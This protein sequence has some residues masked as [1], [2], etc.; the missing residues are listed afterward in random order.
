M[1]NTTRMPTSFQGFGIDIL[2]LG[3][4]L[5]G[6]L[7]IVSL[8]PLVPNDFWWHLKVGEWIYTH[9]SIPTTNMFAWSL[10]ADAP[11]FYGTWLGELLLY[12]LFRFGGLEL[13]IFTRTFLFGITLWLLASEARRR[14]GSWRIAAFMVALV[15]VMTLSNVLV[16]TQIWSWLPFIFYLTLLSRFSDRQLP[17]LWL[18]VLPLIMIFWV[19]AHGA[20]IL[21]LV[22]I[23]IYFVGELIR[24]L[25]KFPSSLPMKDL[26][27]LAMIGFITAL[28]TLINPRF[29]GIVDYVLDLLTD[30]PSQQLII[31]WQS[32]SPQGLVNITFFVSILILLIC[33]AYTKYKP[34][35][36]TL[37]TIVAFLWLAWSGMRY[38][39][40]YALAVMP[41]LAQAIAN[42][43]IKYP[44]LESPRTRANLLIFLILFIP[45]LLVQPWFVEKFPLPETY[46][47]QVWHD[48]PDGPLLSIETPIAAVDYLQGHPGGKLFNEMG[49]GSY[50]VWALPEQGVFIDPRV[51]LYPYEQ[52]QDYIRIIRG[53]DYNL[54]LERYG[55][56]RLLLSKERQPE[57]INVLSTDSAWFLEYEDSFS[58]IW[59]KNR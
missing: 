21:G 38:I 14:S 10:P 26:I 39:V 47:Q 54:I 22:L 30:Q 41:I 49:Y 34:G 33:L 2:W 37:L 42:L 1:K 5:A 17:R 18:L 56:D 19:N 28:A 31:E 13:T 15:G 35:P 4:I 58:Q 32:P 52:W 16:R 53:A 27:W 45:V 23:G 48:V 25:L 3:I 57:L 12:I 7:F 20:F 40:W 55:A 24:I 43:P 44:S 8:I 46:R 9:R 36:I 51:E 59:Q 11:F 6:I 29:F 50:L